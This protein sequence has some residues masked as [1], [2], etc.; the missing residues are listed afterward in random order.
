MI[1]ASYNQYF[2]V[3]HLLSADFTGHGDICRS[4]E[5]AFAQPLMHQRRFVLFGLGGAGKT[6][7]CL[8]YVNLY[9][10]R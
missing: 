4:L 7:T 1:I 3:P 6:Q 10:E 5:N 8:H 2:E 9:R